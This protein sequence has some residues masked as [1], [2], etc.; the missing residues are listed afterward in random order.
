MDISFNSRQRNNDYYLAMAQAA[1]YRLIRTADI[2]AFRHLKD[3]ITKHRFKGEISSFVEGNLNIIRKA[4]SDS[5]CKE[6]I[7]NINEECISLEKQGT[8]LTL[9]KAK[10][11]LTIR[12]ER[13]QKEIGYTIE[14]IGV[15]V[16]GGQVVAGYG[17][18]VKATTFVGK[19]AGAHI[20][21]SGVDALTENAAKLFFGER[22]YVGFMK[23][24][25]MGVAEFLG[26][27]RKVGLIGYHS[28]DMTT[29][30]YG[31]FKLTL[32]PDARRLFRFIPED[33]Y[34]QV[35]T[36][37]RTS[38]ALKFIGAGYKVRIISEIVN[39]EQ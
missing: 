3:P 1:K 7:S 34:R 14:A 10:V 16:G 11:F 17:V 33:Y 31:I 36:M 9:E 28:V 24:G 4:E 30:L 25:Y 21:L 8:M 29:S 6:A 38:L 27:D 32:K 12:M 23:K 35:N 39:E 18:F 26:F 15:V 5:V 2:V 37:S 22:E 19:L 20:T 13:H